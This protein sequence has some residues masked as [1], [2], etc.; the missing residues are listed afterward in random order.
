MNVEHDPSSSA[1]AVVTADSHAAPSLDDLR[2]YCEQRY[3]DDFDEFASTV[4]PFYDVSN[5]YLLGQFGGDEEALAAWLPDMMRNA[6]GAGIRDMGVRLADLDRDGVAAAVVF[7]GSP[8]SNGAFPPVPF[9]DDGGAPPP[10]VEWT[11]KERELGAAG[12]QIYNRWLADFCAGAPARNAGLCQ[13]AAWDVDASVET[14]RWAAEH[15]LR[16]VNFPH[17][18]LSL[19]AYDDP[20]WDPLFAVCA[21]L[22]MPLVTHLGGTHPPYMTGPGGAVTGLMENPYVGGRNIWHLIFSGAFDRH[23]GL[24]LAITEVPG[25][26]FESVINDMES[27]Y[28]DPGRVGPMIRNY[29]EKSPYEYVKEN[30]YIGCSFMSRDEAHT[31]IRL[32][33]TD[34]VM[35]GSDYPHPEGTWL[36]HA[37]DPGEQPSTT[38]LS[39]ANTFAGLGESDVRRMAGGNA[40]RCYELDEAA[41]AQV[42]ER[43]G[44]SVGELT[45]APD[46]DQLPAD[47]KGLGFRRSGAWT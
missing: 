33:L 1:V 18:Q 41:I 11:A 8:D 23:P 26:W 7:H 31:A 40:I 43:V 9:S 19:A 5:P 36:Y 39:L 30:V 4:E 20:V 13:I 2:P 38:R 28:R 27:L 37:D 17:P 35:W 3:L 10:G 21:E 24:T 42:A 29:L 44:P 14:V 47:Y 22:S 34:R 25:T 46:L 45:T 32:G 16:G 6:Q 15:G 12:R